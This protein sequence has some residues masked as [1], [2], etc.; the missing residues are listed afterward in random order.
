MQGSA[1]FFD[2]DPES[3]LIEASQSGSRAA[4]VELVRMHQSRIRSFIGAR[5]FDRSVADDIAQE[6]FISA[7]RSVSGFRGEATFRVWLL[8]IARHR[9]LDHLRAELRISGNNAAANWVV[10][11]ELNAAE[12]EG[13]T[14]SRQDAEL[15]ALEDCIGRLPTD[16]ARLLG[17]H[18]F[19]SRAIVDIAREV[20][21]EAGAI[22]IELFR[23]RKALRS[24]IDGKLSLE[25]NP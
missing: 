17:E 2:N 18:Y 25:V 11:I 14:L 19:K 22:R 13:S 1:K 4:F 9:I 21:K 10:L 5:I 23:I 15:E 16:R 3:K 7:F 12:S 6:V 8:G 20:H 24:C